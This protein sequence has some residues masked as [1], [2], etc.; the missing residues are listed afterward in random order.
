MVHPKTGRVYIASK[1]E[2][3]GGLYEG[4]ATLSAS[5][6]NVFR[7]VGEVPWV[8]DGAFSPDGAEAGAAGLLRAGRIRLEGRGGVPLGDW[9][10]VPGTPVQRQSESVT[11]TPDGARPDGRLG[12]RE[13]P[14]GARPS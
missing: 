14:G 12:G 13:Q 8:T 9:H 11:Y 10:A 1:R 7:K 4:P 5:G 3:G 6:T 2:S